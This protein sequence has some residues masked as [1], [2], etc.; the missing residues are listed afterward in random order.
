MT[1][2]SSLHPYFNAV[3]S[4]EYGAYTPDGFGFS[5]SVSAFGSALGASIVSD[6]YHNFDVFFS[7]SGTTGFNAGGI[8][9]YL[10][11]FS[12]TMD[13]YGNNDSNKRLLEGIAGTSYDFSGGYGYT[14]GYSRP[15]SGNGVH[16]VSSGIGGGVRMGQSKTYSSSELKR[17][18]KNYLK[19]I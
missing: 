3:L 2:K 8:T 7:Y 4:G 10:P 19:S 18:F 5:G 15:E 9:N 14:L 11:S 17:N 13:F 1:K 12:V 16:K 6:K